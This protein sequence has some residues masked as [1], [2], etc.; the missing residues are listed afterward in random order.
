M[1]IYMDK[2]IVPGIE[3]KHAAEAHREDLKIQD[4]YNCRCMTYWVDE[5]K[6]SAFCLIDAPNEEAVRELHE[7]AH[8]LLPH[9]IIQVNSNVVEA[10]LGRIHDPET[11]TIVGGE[12]LK[13]FNDPAFRVI[14][15]AKT[16]PLGLLRHNMGV[17]KTSRLERLLHQSIESQVLKHEGSIVELPQAEYVVS[18]VSVYQAIRCALAIQHELHIA[19]ELLGLKIGLHAGVPV[20]KHDAIFGGTIKFASYLCNI[21]DIGKITLSALINELSKSDYQREAGKEIIE[22]VH[23]S[24][25]NFLELLFDTLAAKWNSPEFDTKTMSKYMAMSQSKLYRKCIDLV[26]KS[27]N[28]LIRTYRLEQSLQLLSSDRNIAQVA[29]D[30]GFNSPSYYAKCFQKQYGLLPLE[31]VKLST[32]AN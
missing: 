9:E 28:I 26:K 14:L 29:F 3:A 16:T 19:A 31:Y 8:G 13:V 27:P 10:F 23:S 32:S 11:Y 17:D 30:S 22:V 20:D 7:A 12:E 2:H 4:L 21:G 5:A 18:F 6:G 24:K 1:P 15:I 25:E